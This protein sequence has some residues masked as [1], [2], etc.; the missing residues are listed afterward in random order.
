MALILY[1]LHQVYKQKVK[2]VLCEHQ[3]VISGLKADAVVLNEAMQREQ[4]E[5]EAEIHLEQEAIS[6]DMQDVESEKLAW[7]IEL[8]CAT[9]QLLNTAPSKSTN[10]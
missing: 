7:E 2:H 1:F 6:V 4:E 10:I 9:Q 5:L 8:V 3:N